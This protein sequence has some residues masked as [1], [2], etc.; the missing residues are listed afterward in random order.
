MKKFNIT[1]YKNNLFYILRFCCYIVHFIL[2]IIYEIILSSINLSILVLHLN[3]KMYPGIISIPLTIKNELGITM[4]ANLI[5]L[6]P[7]SLSIDISQDK[8]LLFLHTI[9]A[10]QK[11]EL[12]HSIKNKLEKPLIK[13][14]K[15]DV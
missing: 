11:L 14:F 2:Y 3:N 5:S 7:G 15:E 6:T 8:K 1:I 9:F 10:N 12:S 13:F 4:L